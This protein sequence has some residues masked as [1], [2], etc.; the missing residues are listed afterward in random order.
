MIIIVGLGNP[1]KKFQKT[2]HN[3]GFMIVESLKLKVK[4]FSDWKNNKKLLSEI[5]EGEINGQ[6]V[7]LAKPQ[8][9]MN[10]SGKAVK[11]LI[12]NIQ[13]QSTKQSFMLG[14][15]H[16]I[17]CSDLASKLWIVHD[18]IDLP[19]GKIRISI[20]RGAA[21]H[22][23]VQSIIDELG[24]KNFVRFKVGIQP[25]TGKP[26]N[27]EKFVL[28]KPSETKPSETG[29]ETKSQRP[30]NRKEEKILKEVIEKTC[31]AIEVAIK[32]GVEKTM[33]KFNSPR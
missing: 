30:F 29:D 32:E 24:T 19:L 11:K 28:Q 10:N 16:K 31:Q 7:I 22:K 23:G 6:K 17:M 8:T 2:R 1:G 3:L 4:S 12:S 18:D 9:F 5:S 15:A 13:N 14:R 25:K 33:Q 27:L 20:A 26:K 21:G